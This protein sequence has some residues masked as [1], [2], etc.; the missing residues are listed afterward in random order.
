VCG[1]VWCVQHTCTMAS[2]LTIELEECT[3]AHSH[4]PLQIMK[5]QVHHVA[6]QREVKREVNREVKREVNREVKRERERER[7]VKREIERE[8]EIE[9]EIEKE[10]E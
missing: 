3:V 6:L 5:L 1:A 4:K 9:K 8:R 7:E 2:Y 10:K